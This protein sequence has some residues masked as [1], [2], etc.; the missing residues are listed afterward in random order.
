L[1]DFIRVDGTTE[2]EVKEKKDRVADALNATGA[3]VEEGVLPLVAALASCSPSRRRAN[4]KPIND[5][6]KTG[7]DIGC[8]LAEAGAALQTEIA[9]LEDRFSSG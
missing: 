7:I 1:I 5:N 6:Q 3:A 8:L 2:V 9:R 4:L